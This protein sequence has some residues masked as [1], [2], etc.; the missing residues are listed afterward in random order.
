[1]FNHKNKIFIANSKYKRSAL[2]VCVCV[3]IWIKRSQSLSTDKKRRSQSETKY[4]NRFERDN[5]LFTFCTLC[6]ELTMGKSS[7]VWI[8]NWSLKMD[9][10]L[11]MLIQW[12]SFVFLYCFHC[13]PLPCSNCLS[14]GRL[15]FLSDSSFVCCVCVVCLCVSVYWKIWRTVS[16]TI[17][18][19]QSISAEWIQVKMRMMMGWDTISRHS[20]ALFNYSNLFPCEYSIWFV[21]FL[22][23]SSINSIWHFV[24]FSV[25]AVCFWF[26]FVSLGSSYVAH[27]KSY[28]TMSKPKVNLSWTKF[29]CHTADP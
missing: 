23:K 17:C 20:A 19:A 27:W 16:L 13:Y 8:Q 3:C 5:N 10:P 15:C 24:L 2:E 1:M 22:G 14:I 29:V 4:Q 28:E 21:V 7:I 18:M 12:K 25:D 11:S 26:D 6:M 9:E